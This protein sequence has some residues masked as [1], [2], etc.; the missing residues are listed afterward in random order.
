[1]FHS[2]V[3]LQVLAVI[4]FHLIDIFK[5]Y[6]HFCLFNLCG[7]QFCCYFVSLYACYLT[8][9]LFLIVE[10][11]VTGELWRILSRLSGCKSSQASES[12]HLSTI[13]VSNALS[14]AH[15]FFTMH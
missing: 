6:F 13:S 5:K 2:H 4:L 8:F 14:Q 1:M 7:Y 12:L 9:L 10:T 15:M 3:S 11:D